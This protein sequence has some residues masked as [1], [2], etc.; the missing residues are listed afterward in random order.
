MAVLAVVSN[1]LFRQWLAENCVVAAPVLMFFVNAF[2]WLC[3][4]VGLHLRTKLSAGDSGEMKGEKKR[5]K[6]QSKRKVY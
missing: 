1:D 2:L 6:K 3:Y 5:S 4:K